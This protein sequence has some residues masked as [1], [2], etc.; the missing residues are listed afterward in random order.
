MLYFQGS[1]EHRHPRGASI[2][3]SRLAWQFNIIIRFDHNNKTIIDFEEADT[4]IYQ[5][6]NAT[7]TPAFG[8]G[9]YYFFPPTALFAGGLVLWA[10]TVHSYLTSSI[11]LVISHKT[12]SWTNVSMALFTSLILQMLV[13]HTGYLEHQE[14]FSRLD[15]GEISAIAYRLQDEKQQRLVMKNDV[16]VMMSKLGK[17]E[18]IVEEIQ[19]S[20]GK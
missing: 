15:K 9:D 6:S 20:I 3:C 7:F 17:L 12:K 1:R 18:L 11:R 13:F 19:Q 10:L 2:R 4:M 16:D 5:P 8:L 14:L